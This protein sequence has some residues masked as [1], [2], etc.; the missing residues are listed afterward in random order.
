MCINTVQNDYTLIR[1]D[2]EFTFDKIGVAKLAE[3][4]CAVSNI[5]G[6]FP[7]IAVHVDTEWFKDENGKEYNED[8]V[9]LREF[10]EN[11]EY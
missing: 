2:T 7:C 4:Y 9:S 1:S 3:V 10:L 6:L 8:M 11:I 5:K